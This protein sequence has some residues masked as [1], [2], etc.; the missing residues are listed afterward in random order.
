MPNYGTVG[1]IWLR[2]SSTAAYKHI[3]HPSQHYALSSGDSGA[4][5]LPPPNQGYRIWMFVPDT[6]LQKRAA[7]CCDRETA[8]HHLL[9]FRLWLVDIALV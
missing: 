7:E 4:V 3:M 1:T 2:I 8:L 9:R 5:I 6:G